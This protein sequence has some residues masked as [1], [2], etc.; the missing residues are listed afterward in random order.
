MSDVRCYI[1]AEGK[2]IAQVNDALAGPP[3]DFYIVILSGHD[4]HFEELLALHESC[5]NPP[6]VIVSEKSFMFDK[7]VL[8]ELGRLQEDCPSFG[9]CVEDYMIRAEMAGFENVP[10]LGD[11]AATSPLATRYFGKREIPI[12]EGVIL[13]GSM[14]TDAK[15][16][17]VPGYRLAPPAK[18]VIS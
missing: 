8:M 14:A 6:G 10:A 16:L 9:V 15:A 4:G 11:G 18:M 7:D 2:T 13:R 5:V 3:L 12:P 17:K 1:E